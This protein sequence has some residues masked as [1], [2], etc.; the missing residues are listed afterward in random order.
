MK[1]FYKTS[2]FSNLTIFRVTTLQISLTSPD[3]SR[4]SWPFCKYGTINNCYK[5]KCNIHIL[6]T[7]QHLA[8]NRIKQWQ[9][10]KVSNTK[11]PVD[12]VVRKV[13]RQFSLT[14]FSPD[15]SLHD[16]NLCHFVDFPIFPVVGHH[17][18]QL[19]NKKWIWYVS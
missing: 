4:H 12:A 16:Q 3:N 10:V 8:I 9:R 19:D 1:F 14:R 13:F 17:A 18:Y 6:E 7:K 2:P 5:L 11:K 15:I